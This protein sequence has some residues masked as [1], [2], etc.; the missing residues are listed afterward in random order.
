MANMRNFC[1]IIAFH[2]FATLENRLT[3]QCPSSWP[4]VI[5]M[6]KKLAGTWKT[7]RILAGPNQWQQVCNR[8]NPEK[9]GRSC[10]GADCSWLSSK[11]S[12][13][14]P[15][16]FRHWFSSKCWGRDP[17]GWKDC[18]YARGNSDPNDAIHHFACRNPGTVYILPRY[19]PIS[20][21]GWIQLAT[22]T[23]H[24]SI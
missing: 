23:I 24:I 4:V 18:E 15:V 6:K 9:T 8:S 21:A 7:Y 19:H 13:A 20:C 17:A 2:N 1:F 5:T 16:N 10:E 22:Q 14:S 3:Y 12:R 11:V